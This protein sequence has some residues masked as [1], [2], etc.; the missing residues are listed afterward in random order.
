MAGRRPLPDAGKETTRRNIQNNGAAPGS[1]S[2]QAAVLGALPPELL[3]AIR[4]IQFRASHLVTDVFLGEYHS[5]FRGRGIEFAEVREYQPGD[6]IRTIDWNVTARMGRPYVKRYIE[7]RELTVLLVVDVSASEGF[8]TARQTKQ[9]IAAEIGALLAFSAI[10]SNDKVGL[11]AFSDRIERFVPPKKGV[12]HVLRVVRELLY[13]QPAGTGTNIAEAIDFLNRITKRRSIVF[14]MSDFLAGGYD[15]ALK[16]AAQRHEVIALTLTD[17][18]ELELPAVGMLYLE[19]AETGERLLIDSSDPAVRTAFARRA[20]EEQEE[21]RRLF[22][23]TGVDEVR[24]S[25]DRSYVEPLLSY[26]R[27][28]A[29]KVAAARAGR[30]ARR[31]AAA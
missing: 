8:S 17:P 24:L 18:R 23:S 5:V 30:V 22:R 15:R 31:R 21:R 27:T 9:E 26:F 11:I 29:Q 12:Q 7:E 2:A 1:R 4:R 14:L 6:D 28:K 16:I 10:R 20:A 3:R 13:V 25:T 19:D